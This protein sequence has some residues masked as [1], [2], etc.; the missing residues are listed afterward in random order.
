MAWPEIDKYRELEQAYAQGLE[1]FGRIEQ[2]Y[3]DA[4]AAGDESGGLSDKYYRQL[5]EVR[6]ELATTRAQLTER[7][8]ALAKLH[9]EAV[10]KAIL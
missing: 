1:R 5:E 8:D 10:Q 2:L 9:D 3:R 6:D 7:R 4:S